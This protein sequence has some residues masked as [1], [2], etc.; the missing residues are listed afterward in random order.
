MRLVNVQGRAGLVVGDAVA[1]V[2]RR[3]GGRFAADPMEAVA[4]WDA[5][6]DW[7]AGLRRGDGDTALDETLLSAID[8]TSAE[9]WP[10]AMASRPR[11]TALFPRGG[12]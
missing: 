2:E 10:G 6:A 11:A 4:S 9:F 8:K 5:L 7:S 12:R 3:S 1:D